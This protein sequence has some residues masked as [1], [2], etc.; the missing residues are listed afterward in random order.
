MV[1][2]NPPLLTQISSYFLVY[3]LVWR[4]LSLR[5]F[6]RKEEGKVYFLDF[7]Y[8]KIF[9]FHLYTYLMVF[10]FR[11]LEIIFLQINRT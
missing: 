4:V 1:R 11:I 2:A 7:M 8:L 6:L 10:S 3:F 5:N 9:L